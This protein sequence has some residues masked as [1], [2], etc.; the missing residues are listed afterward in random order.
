MKEIHPLDWKLF[1]IKQ[2]CLVLQYLIDLKMEEK[3]NSENWQEFLTHLYNSINIYNKLEY[4]ERKYP[5]REIRQIDVDVSKTTFKFF[6]L[7]YNGLKK[8]LDALLAAA[9]GYSFE[10]NVSEW[11][12]TV[13]EAFDDLEY[14][15]EYMN[16]H[17]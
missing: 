2:T 16:E 9:D 3:P 15:D 6:V 10:H 1:E 17:L 12:D 14:Y 11:R 5:D 13:S 8:L 4:L 7:K